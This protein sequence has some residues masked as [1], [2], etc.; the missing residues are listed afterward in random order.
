M[1]IKVR[2]GLYLGDSSVT[3]DDLKK[4]GVT[5][6]EFV[7]TPSMESLAAIEGEKIEYFVVRLYRP[8]EQRVNK[9]YI[10]DI[11]CHIPK[12]MMSNGEVVAVLGQT[13]LVRGA[14]VVARA[15]CELEIKSIYEVFVELKNVL[16][17]E[18]DI[19]R[20]YL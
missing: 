15:I 4:E 5:M 16:P 7:Y 8:E 12:Y 11:A 17:K 18:F 19:G 13:G 9:P 6:V 3:I 14:F 20:A 2:D 10:K 1:L